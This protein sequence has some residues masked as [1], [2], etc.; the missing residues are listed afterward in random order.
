MPGLLNLPKRTNRSVPGDDRAAEIVVQ[1]RA[2]DVG[3]VFEHSLRG[4]ERKT[5]TDRGEVRVGRRTKIDVQIFDAERP[6][7][8]EFPFSAD[9]GSPAGP[10]IAVSKQPILAGAQA[11]FLIGVRDVAEGNAAGDV[12]Q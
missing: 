5:S 7:G 12:Q 11:N 9:A 4:R 6:V 3:L 10:G 2:D 1:L 8:S